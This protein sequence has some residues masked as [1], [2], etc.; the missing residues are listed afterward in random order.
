MCDAVVASLSEKDF[1]RCGAAIRRAGHRPQLPEPLR[2][3]GDTLRRALTAQPLDPPSRKQLAVDAGAQRALKFLI[4]SR[5]VVEISSD[6]VMDA[7]VV[8]D[9]TAKVKAFVARNGP[10]TVSDLRQ[11]LGGSRRIVVP[12]LEYL[13]RTFV[14]VRRGDRRALR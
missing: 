12:L 3:A 9:A 2:A 4:D 8:A 1:P 13:D 14:T 11:F 10:A 7:A 6:L 5:E